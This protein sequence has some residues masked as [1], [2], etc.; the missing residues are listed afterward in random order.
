MSSLP[1]LQ[2]QP[3]H[4]SAAGLVIQAPRLE[5]LYS[6]LRIHSVHK[7]NSKYNSSSFYDNKFDIVTRSA[8]SQASK[9]MSFLHLADQVEYV[10]LCSSVNKIGE[11]LG[12]ASR[13]KDGLM[14]IPGSRDALRGETRWRYFEIQQL[15]FAEHFGFSCTVLLY[16]F[17]PSLDCCCPYRYNS[18][19]SVNA[20][21]P[22]EARLFIL[23][24]S[25]PTLCSIALNLL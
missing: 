2:N 6:V 22:E 8:A 14:S 10:E 23:Q 18:Y 4:R 11:I 20:C 3:I 15:L 17:S 7:G 21:A 19:N 13:E 9:A 5:V 12:M 25:K 24:E 1:I 16:H